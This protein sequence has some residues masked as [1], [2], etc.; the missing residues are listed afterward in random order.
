MG[1][2]NEAVPK[3]QLRARTVELAKLLLGKNP[4]TLRAC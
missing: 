2:V 4:N 3:A 1:L